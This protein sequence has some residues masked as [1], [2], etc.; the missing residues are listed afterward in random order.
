M[1]NVILTQNTGRIA[2]VPVNSITAILSMAFDSWDGPE[3]ERPGCIIHTN[4][5][6][7]HT[8]FLAGS[9]TEV[10]IEVAQVRESRKGALKIGRIRDPLPIALKVGDD[11]SHLAEGAIL[12]FE[13][14]GEGDDM[15]YRVQYRRHDGP[16][17]DL[18]VSHTSENL[19]TLLA[20][21]DTKEN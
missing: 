1:A 17:F 5:R 19:A 13:E 4:F 20:A 11:E 12:A 18:D 10:A 7:A 3:N 16:V 8:Y 2:C 9:A 21:T 15:R 14:T 6:G